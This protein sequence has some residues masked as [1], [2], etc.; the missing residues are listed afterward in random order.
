M[1]YVDTHV[2][3]WL[4]RNE[5]ERFSPAARRHLEA[6]ELVASPAVVLELQFLYEVGRFKPGARKILE[7]LSGDIGL[8]VCELPFSRVAG[9]ALDLSWVRDPFDRLIVANAKAA[10]A[11]LVTKDEMI[12]RH[13]AAA[14]W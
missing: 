9:A 13:Y 6:D 3:L 11:P 12:R 1:T 14:I 7:D 2:L 5:L 4:Y 8:T 10:R